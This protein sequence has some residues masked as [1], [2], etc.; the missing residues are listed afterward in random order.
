MTPLK[1][2]FRRR[3]I[4][5]ERLGFPLLEMPLGLLGDGLFRSR[6][7]R[8]GCLVPGVLFG[9]NGLHHYYPAVRQISASLDLSQFLLE[10]HSSIFNY[11]IP[12]SRAIA[13]PLLAG[14]SAGAESGLGA[15]CR[16]RGPIQLDRSPKAASAGTTDSDE[17][18]V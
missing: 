6:A 9:V 5:T 18:R 10:E 13:S 8:W 4:E 16:K 15:G 12:G 11:M 3:W 17:E 2:I 14:P 1:W 7:F